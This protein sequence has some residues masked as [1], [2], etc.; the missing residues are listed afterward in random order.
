MS[1]EVA[2][3]ILQQ[4]KEDVEES[5]ARIRECIVQDEVRIEGSRKLLQELRDTVASLKEAIEMLNLPRS[6]DGEDK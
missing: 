4:R 1:T 5:I 2:I 6:K 3:R